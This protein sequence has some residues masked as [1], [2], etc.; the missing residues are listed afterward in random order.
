MLLSVSE[1]P[2]EVQSALDALRG[3]RLT[4][5]VVSVIVAGLIGFLVASLITGRVKRLAAAAGQL[6][7]GHLDKPLNPSGRDEIGDLGRTLD[8]MRIALAETFDALSSERD[9]LPPSSSRSR[10]R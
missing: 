6:A 8:S 3:Q 7:E 1:R 9:R 10:R 5:L 4:A 2:E